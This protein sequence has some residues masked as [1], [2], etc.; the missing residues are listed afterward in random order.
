MAIPRA[1][2]SDVLPPAG[3]GWRA[4]LDL[5]CERRAGRTVLA[6]KRQRGP[7]TLQRPFYPEGDVCQLYLLHPPAGVV[8][9]DRLDVR[10]S[11]G[12]GAHA[13]ATTPGAAKLYRSAGP[14]AVLEQRL[15]IAPGGALEWLPHE[16]ILFPGARACSR[17]SVELSGDARFIGWE[18]QSLGRP[19]IGERFER[20]VLHARLV[21]SRDGRPLLDDLLRVAGPRDLDAPSGLRGHPVT[22]TLVATGTDG[23]DLVA[24]REALSGR[25][26]LLFGITRLEDVL[27]ARCLATTVEPVQRLF[28][29]LWEALR[30][31]LLGRAACPPRIWST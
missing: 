11:V 27:V 16:S 4:E 26:G 1:A 14:E 15:R 21:L 17:T 9:G 19:V 29:A 5:C 18:V 20:G 31:R 2:G 24:A 7:L 3:E 28:C 23:A 10:L 25:S 6:R 13:L 12:P 8:G 30:P 22:G